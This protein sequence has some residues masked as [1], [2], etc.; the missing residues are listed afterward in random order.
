MVCI[1]KNMPKHC[2]CCSVESKLMC[3]LNHQFLV[4]SEAGQKILRKD[5]EDEMKAL[6]RNK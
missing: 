4:L 1:F 2:T 3:L 6:R 5:L